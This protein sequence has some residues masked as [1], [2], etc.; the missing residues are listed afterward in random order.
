MT[1]PSA[2]PDGLAQLRERIVRQVEAVQTDLAANRPVDDAIEQLVNLGQAYGALRAATADRE[3]PRRRWKAAIIPGL[4]LAAVFGLQV[5]HHRPSNLELDVRAGSVSLRP[6]S[7][8]LT[9]SSRVTELNVAGATRIELPFDSTCAPGTFVVSD[10]SVALVRV[11]GGPRTGRPATVTVNTVLGTRRGALE[12]AAGPGRR[13][14]M[15]AERGARLAASVDGAVIVTAGGTAFRCAVSAPAPLTVTADSSQLVVDFALVDST[16]RVIATDLHVEALD[17]EAVQYAGDG[18][19]VEP[20]RV[21]T[22]REGAL[23]LETMTDQSYRLRESEHLR[24]TEP[25]GALRSLALR[26][27]GVALAFVGNARDVHVGTAGF[28]R[29]LTPS[30]LEYVRTRHTLIA[31]WGALLWLLGVAGSLTVWWKGGK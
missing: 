29:R 6:D 15:V 14:R 22:I 2:A 21:S 18:A 12:F 31:P 16:T 17:F 3:P 9:V 28:E 7:Q 11:D 27:D 26:P 30:Q 5:C 13:W 4:G 24:L 19:D 10:A 1:Q 25:R 23:V 20:A 8:A